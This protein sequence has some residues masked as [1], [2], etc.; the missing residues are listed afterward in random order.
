MIRA[1][2]RQILAKGI[3]TAALVAAS[4]LQA[5]EQNGSLQGVVNDAAGKPV[6][7][8]FVKLKNDARRL[9]FMVISQEQGRFEAKDLP[10]GQYRLQGVG[11][12]FES[13]WS[14]NVAAGDS[15]KVV[16]ALTK[17]R[18]PLLPPAWP[19]RIP[20]DQVR[21][22]SLDL[23]EGEG[24][25]L[26]AERCGTCHDLRRVVVKRSSQDDWDHTVDRM[27]TRMMVAL[28]LDFTPAE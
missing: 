2:V 27:R 13:N 10:P 8:A 1:S 12:A 24:K 18:G 28:Q 7:G 21:T 25:T 9:T 17:Q 19:Q 3:A 16:L 4:S 15:A 6:V 5:A 22:A 23:P 20:E 26:V 11:G 14:G